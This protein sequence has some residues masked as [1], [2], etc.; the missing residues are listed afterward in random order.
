MN[1]T[2][3]DSV[4]SDIVQGRPALS[5]DA[6]ERILRLRTLMTETERR[7]FA[8]ELDRTVVRSEA[9]R[10]WV[11]DPECYLAQLDP[12]VVGAIVADV[13]ARTAELEARASERGWEV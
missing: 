12:D 11:A 13:A 6:D 10:D 4:I 1:G 2:P 8:D 7:A 3:R 5:E 9:W